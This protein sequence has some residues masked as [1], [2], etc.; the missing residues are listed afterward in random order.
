VQVGGFSLPGAIIESPAWEAGP[1]V[2]GAYEVCGDDLTSNNTS[3]PDP[4]RL[5]RNLGVGAHAC[6]LKQRPDVGA[7]M[8]ADLTG[9]LRFEIRQPDLIGP[10][11]GIDHNGMRAFVVAAVWIVVREESP[12]DM[13]RGLL[14]GSRLRIHGFHEC[15]CARGCDGRA[16]FFVHVTD[17]AGL[18]DKVAT[19]PGALLLQEHK[20]FRLLFPLCN[21]EWRKC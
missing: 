19:I 5:K 6:G 4:E 8:P 14:S 16:V 15:H 1:S 12:L 13:V 11:V 20:L 7:A 18:D 9:E 21:A 3:R 2:G 10:A 17:P